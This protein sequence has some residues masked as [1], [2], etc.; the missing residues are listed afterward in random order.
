MKTRKVSLRLL[1]CE[2]RQWAEMKYVEHHNC[3]SCA[4]ILMRLPDLWCSLAA[5][6]SC[7]KSRL[8]RPLTNAHDGVQS[9]L[10][11]RSRSAMNLISNLYGQ[12]HWIRARSLRS[13]CCLLTAI[14]S[15]GL[16]KV[17]SKAVRRHTRI[18]CLIAKKLNANII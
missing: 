18:P 15:R 9:S 5:N 12:S 8:M 14:L 4:R 10:F 6:A 1:Q 13:R 2:R 11:G 3:F 17:C 7:S 16:S